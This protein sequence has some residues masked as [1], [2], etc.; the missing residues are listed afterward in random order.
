MQL[1]RRG[2]GDPVTL[3]AHGLGSGVAETRALASGV[4]GTRV[5]L[6]FD[7]TGGRFSYAALAAQL[8][9][10]AD[11]SAATGAVGASMGAGALCALLAGTPDRFARCV[12]FLPAVLD[13]PRTAEA[14]NRLDELAA[15]AGAGDRPR[16]AELVAAEL[17]PESRGT[18]E[19]RRYT[20]RRAQAL[21]EPAAAAA[22]RA[23]RSAVAVADRGALRG[24][25]ADCLVVGQRG[26]P[27]HPAAV[28]EEL[29][30][31]LPRSQLRLFPDAFTVWRRRDELRAL[32][33]GF[34]GGAE[35]AR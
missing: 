3:F 2:H 6:P 22:L 31:A 20:L 11:H 35:F 12:F 28:A 7:L 34:L 25:T 23:A 32:L 15:A 1:L 4:P 8:A 14:A 18:A 21:T 5:F 26:D 27:L 33:G 9:A 10:A 29:A 16:V 13:R 24:V 19:G 30:A 17:P